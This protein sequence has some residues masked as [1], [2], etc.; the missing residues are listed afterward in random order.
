LAPLVS[1][2]R[3]IWRAISWAV[4][5]SSPLVRAENEPASGLYQ[6][7]SGNYS[8][9]CGIAGSDFGYPL[10]SENQSFVRLTF[11]AQ[12]NFGTLTILGADAQTVFRTIP[13]PSSGAINFSFD[14]GLVLSNSIVF[15]VDPGP[16]PYGTYW[17]YTVSNSAGGL[18]M[19][20][21]LGTLQSMCT[22]VPTRFSQS[23]V[24]AVLV[25][26]PRLRIT[27]FSKDGPLL[28]IQGN[29]GWQNVIEASSDLLTWASISTNVMPNTLCPICPY[30]LYHDVESTNLT[31]RFYRCFE[32]P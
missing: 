11:D 14:H 24:V 6:I 5:L 10:P 7:T 22:D 27:E 1:T 21:M 15:H 19:D 30:I 18:R 16:P 3:I 23:N 29:A 2:T 26:P 13:C 12:R 9:C 31:R 17:N 25:P 8:A 4:L 28:F 20:G 32:V